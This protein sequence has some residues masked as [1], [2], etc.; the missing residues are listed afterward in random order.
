MT[1]DMWMK[2]RTRRT[3]VTERQRLRALQPR[4]AQAL[5]VVAAAQPKP[6]HCPARNYTGTYTRG[7]ACEHAYGHEGMHRDKHMNEWEGEV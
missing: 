5:R 4:K 7:Y 2:S 3:S 6:Q 1:E